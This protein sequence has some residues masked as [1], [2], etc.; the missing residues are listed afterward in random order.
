MIKEVALGEATRIINHGPVVLVSSKSDK[1]NGVTP[2]AWTMPVDKDPPMI[3][4]EIGEGHFIYNCI[5]ETGDFVVN[6]PSRNMAEVVVACGSCSGWKKDKFSEFKLSP[7][8][9]KKVVSPGIQGSLAFMECELVRDVHLL[10]K[11]NLV[12]GKV[13]YAEAEEKAF[14]GHWLFEEEELTTLHH[15]GNKVFCSPA[16]DLIDMRMEVER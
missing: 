5:M 4:L 2:V 8:T 9:S 13:K 11:Y 6:V 15:L 14:R 3:L 1:R 7:H 16:T 12:M 10:E